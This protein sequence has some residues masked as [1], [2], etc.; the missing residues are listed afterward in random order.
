MER[1]GIAHWKVKVG[2]DAIA[3]ASDGSIQKG[4]CTRLVDYNA[5]FISL[6]PDAFDDRDEVMATLRH[7][8]FHIVL[9]PY[10]L[11]SSAIDRL[12]L[13]GAT[14]NVLARV[15]DHS[16]E[17]AVVNLVRMFVGLTSRD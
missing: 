12:E 10:D 16:C 5:A 14:A 17:K 3:P 9:S 2:Y 4:D 11:F 15:W 1:L 13:P 6:N 7:E 8:L